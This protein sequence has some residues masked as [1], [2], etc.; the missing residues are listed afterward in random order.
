MIKYMITIIFK[1]KPKMAGMEVHS[2]VKI[3]SHLLVDWSLQIFPLRHLRSMMEMKMSMD[4]ISPISLT[5]GASHAR[6]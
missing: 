1:I 5:R 3:L 2:K 4:I 6:G